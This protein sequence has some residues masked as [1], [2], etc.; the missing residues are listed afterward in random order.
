[1]R[2]PW[3]PWSRKVS[4]STSICSDRV[5]SSPVTM[6]LAPSTAPVVEKAQ[7]EPHCAER[8]AAEEGR[9]LS[10]GP[11]QVRT[12]VGWRRKRAPSLGG[13]SPAVPRAPPRLPAAAAHQELVLHGPHRALLPPVNVL[14]RD[15]VLV[16]EA[17]AR[18]EPGLAVLERRGAV[19]AQALAVLLQGQ[20]GK[21]VHA[22]LQ[23]R[24][25]EQGGVRQ[26]EG[27]GA[28]ARRR[29]LAGG[30]HASRP[31]GILWG[32]ALRRPLARR[33]CPA[34][35]RCPW[36]SRRPAGHANKLTLHDPPHDAPS[37]S[38]GGRCSPQ[39]T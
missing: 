20:V 8:E 28:Q 1:M 21:L 27:G 39:R 5:T 18:L 32:G 37:G 14:G 38:C 22:E 9:Q 19:K 7:Q 16:D 26:R 33:H 12:H 11:P 17:A 15:G 31:A 25:A 36:G 35:G 24:E 2:P 6:A 13:D 4:Q 29:G 34:R 30:G 3:Q 10:A 23:V